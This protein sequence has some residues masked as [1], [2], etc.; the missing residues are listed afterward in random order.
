MIIPGIFMLV[1]LIVS[2]AALGASLS[3]P[4]PFPPNWG[5]DLEEIEKYGWEEAVRRYEEGKQ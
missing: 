1:L 2:I 4:R 5:P 3:H